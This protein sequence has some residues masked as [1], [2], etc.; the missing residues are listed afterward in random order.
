LP[1]LAKIAYDA[2]KAKAQ[3]VS[4]VSGAVLPDWEDLN[5]SIQEAWDAASQA[6][7]VAALGN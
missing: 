6:V 2:Y 1:D 7:A 5:G 3:G 4:L